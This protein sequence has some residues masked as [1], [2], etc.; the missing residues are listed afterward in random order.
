MADPEKLVRA[1][2]RDRGLMETF[3]DFVRGLKMCI[4]DSL[5]KEHPELAEEEY[6]PSEEFLEQTENETDMSNRCV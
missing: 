6:V 2:E 5:L 4:R 3:L 1:V